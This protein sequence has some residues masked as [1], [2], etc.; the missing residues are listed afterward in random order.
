MINHLEVS[1]KVA[2]FLMVVQITIG[3]RRGA[4]LGHCLSTG[5]RSRAG[6]RFGHLRGHG[7]GAAQKQL[8]P[9][10][11]SGTPGTQTLGVVPTKIAQSEGSFRQEPFER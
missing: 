10:R 4:A 6:R 8:V 7:G 1:L 2:N 11:E 5:S 9:G 3:L